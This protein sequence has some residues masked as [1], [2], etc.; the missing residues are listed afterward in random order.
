[1]CAGMV[2]RAEIFFLFS[3]QLRPLASSGYFAGELSFLSLTPHR[4]F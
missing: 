3:K 2:E 1:M 4:K